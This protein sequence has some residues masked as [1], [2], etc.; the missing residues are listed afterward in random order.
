MSERSAWT[1]WVGEPAAVVVV[2]SSDGRGDYQ[3]T[4]HV[5]DPGGRALNRPF[6]EC[7]CAAWRLQP[8]TR[9]GDCK[10]I[11]AA[12]EALDGGKLRGVVVVA[13]RRDEVAGG[14]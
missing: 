11:R 4:L 6:W 10:H 7:S 12:R 9:R 13:P 3:C 8:V 1:T 5:R 14:A 2:D